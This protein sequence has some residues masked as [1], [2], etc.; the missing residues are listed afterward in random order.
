MPLALL[1]KGF[2]SVMVM[3][4]LSMMWGYVRGLTSGQRSSWM[5]KMP[6]YGWIGC[7]VIASIAFH[8]LT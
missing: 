8:L 7:L 1:V 5:A 4:V 6:F 3:T 2:Y